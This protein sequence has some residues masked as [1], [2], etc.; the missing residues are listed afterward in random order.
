MWL[1]GLDSNQD[2]GL[3]RPVSCRWTTPDCSFIIGE[4]RLT[5][6]ADG[7]TGRH[8]DGATGRMGE[9]PRRVY[10]SFSM[11][12]VTSS[13]KRRMKSFT[14]S[15]GSML[16]SSMSGFRSMAYMSD[17]VTSAPCEAW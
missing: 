13:E 1:R 6:K 4:F 15:S 16:S 7:E 2:P 5:V 10:L 3:Q 17:V 14:Y 12:R 11:R 8:G 9:T